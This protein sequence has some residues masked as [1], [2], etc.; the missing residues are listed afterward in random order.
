MTHRSWTGFDNCWIR[1]WWIITL[2]CNWWGTFLDFLWKFETCR[3]PAFLSSGQWP[4]PSPK[5]MVLLEKEGYG[6]SDGDGEVG[7]EQT[8]WHSQS[9]A[10]T[11]VFVPCFALL[12]P[13]NL[14]QHQWWEVRQMPPLCQLLLP[15]FLTVS[16]L[17]FPFGNKKCRFCMRKYL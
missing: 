17:V 10:H 16:N 1:C 11:G 4:L 5:S 9:R 6:W 15:F 7:M 8:H 2:F 3:T 13:H 12:P 14:Q